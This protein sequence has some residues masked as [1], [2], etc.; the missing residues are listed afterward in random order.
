MAAVNR[1]AVL[2]S[3]GDSSG[4]NPCIRSITRCAI[5]RGLEVFGVRHG[6]RGLIE[7]EIF[8]MNA[9]SVSGI[10][11]QGGTV[12]YTSRCPEFHYEPGR[13]K[14][15]DN[16]RT[17]GID[18]LVVIGGDGSYRG[19]LELHRQT[20]IA[21]IGVPGTIDNDIAGTDYTIGYDTAVNVAM[22][23][24]DK[25]RD[26]ATSHGRLLLVEVMGRHAGYIALEVGIASGAED[27][28]IH[29]TPT[30]LDQTVERLAAGRE[31][32]KRSSIIVVAEGDEAGGAFE[33][34]RLI[35][36]KTGYTL[37][38]SI[39]GYLQRGGSPTARERL[40]AS[41]LG[42][43]AVEALRADRNCHAVGTS[44]ERMTTVHLEEAA[45]RRPEIEQIDLDLIQ[46][47]SI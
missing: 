17:K 1:I 23:A 33:T 32:G 8:P 27:I 28:L 31:R 9:S 15:A 44:R 40:M 4:M 30:D 20:G 14:A 22:E 12:L 45:R 43:Y 19:A 18:A 42:Y 16:L 11:N 38:V 7:D 3:G 21:V 35:E 2:T 46:A 10:I 24:I 34:A 6:F 25:I 37:R 39:L 41:R 47:L 29:E 5:W 26:T 36:G 13:G